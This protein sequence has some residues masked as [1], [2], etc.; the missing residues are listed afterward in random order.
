MGDGDELELD[1]LP[2]LGAAVVQAAVIVG[3]SDAATVVLGANSTSLPP[4]KVAQDIVRGALDAVL[5]IPGADRFRELTVVE[6][7][8]ARFTEIQ[9]ALTA[10]Q[11]ELPLDVVI[12]EIEVRRTT[13]GIL[14][15]GHGPAEHLQLGLT[16][17]GDELKVSSIGDG[18]CEFAKAFQYPDIVAGNLSEELRERV[19]KEDAGDARIAAMR[20]IGTQLYNAF[21]DNS[22]IDVPRL[23]EA[24]SG[25]FVVLRLDDSTVDLPWELLTLGGDEQVVLENRFAR[26]IEIGVRGRQAAYAP[27]GER[28]SVLVVGD[29]TGD[30]PAARREAEAVAE[31]LEKRGDAD[32]TFLS[33]HVTY[34]D[35]S[36]KLDSQPYDIFHYAGHARF[37]DLREDAGGLELVDGKIMTA[38]DLGSRRYLPRLFVANACYSGATGDPRLQV[39]S[40]RATRNLVTGVLSAGARGFVGANWAI[41]DEAAA[42]FAGAFYDELLVADDAPRGTLG[43]AVRLGRRAIVEKHGFE[44]AAWAAYVLYGSPWKRA[45]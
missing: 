10:M 23:L 45:W 39:A 28:L 18:A 27:K 8:P 42:T 35:L 9:A 2:E 22:G 40:R 3:A 31:V 30:L 5:R 34:G 11:H 17:S 38:Q 15:S 26:Q 24:N 33:Q 6:L 20:G 12:D 4:A 41:D 36:K 19:L 37:D 1:R 7:D 13:A 29:P 16:R 44:Q 43:E 14:A 25:G 21:L 32:V